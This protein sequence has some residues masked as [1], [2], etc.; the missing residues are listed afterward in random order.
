MIKILFVSW[1]LAPTNA[2]SLLNAMNKVKNPHLMCEKV[3][4]GVKSLTSQIKEL[5]EKAGVDPNGE[6]FQ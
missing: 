6:S 3:Y 2:A 1:Q 5:G 4:E